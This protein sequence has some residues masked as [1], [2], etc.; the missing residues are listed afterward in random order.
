MHIILDSGLI[1]TL[2]VIIFFATSVAGSN[3]EYAVS[4]VIVQL[5]GITF[6]LIIVQ[7]NTGDILSPGMAYPLTVIPPDGGE[8]PLRKANNGTKTAPTFAIDV[9]I[10]VNRFT[11]VARDSKDNS[12]WKSDVSGV[13]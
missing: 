12:H 13:V 10:E 8:T 5:I 3:A 4:D 7:V 1:Y 9:E 6:N 2:S 11:D